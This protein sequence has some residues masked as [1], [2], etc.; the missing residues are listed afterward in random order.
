MHVAPPNKEDMFR[1]LE[2]ENVVHSCD[3][4]EEEGES[5]AIH[6]SRGGGWTGGV[7]VCVG[8]GGAA[9]CRC[10]LVRAAVAQYQQASWTCEPLCLA[11]GRRG[12]IR[13]WLFAPSLT[14]SLQR[15]H[16]LSICQV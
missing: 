4:D 3:G 14:H 15:G 7:C 8:G 1:A 10:Y 16:W 9:R 5:A 6:S 12:G 11:V 2:R 13:I